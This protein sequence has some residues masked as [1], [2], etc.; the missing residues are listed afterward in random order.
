MTV[1]KIFVVK[2]WK[3][4]HVMNQIL[5]TSWRVI[6]YGHATMGMRAKKI[7]ARAPTTK[8]EKLWFDT[9]VMTR[10]TPDGQLTIIG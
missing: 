8:K 7:V 9:C 3:D 6:A 1:D 10:L 4:V 5:D 2:T